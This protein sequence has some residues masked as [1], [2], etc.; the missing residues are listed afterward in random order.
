MSSTFGTPLA[1][2]AEGTKVWI[3]IFN[4][5]DDAYYDATASSYMA[6]YFS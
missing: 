2:G 3:L 4:I 5:L 1:R 6:G